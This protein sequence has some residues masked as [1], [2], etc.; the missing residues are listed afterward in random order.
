MEH[1]SYNDTNTEENSRKSPAAKIIIA[2]AIVIFLICVGVMIPFIM[3][4]NLIGD[5]IKKDTTQYNV[6]ITAVITENRVRE[7]DGVNSADTKTGKVYTPVYEYE[8]RG[9]TYSVAGSV[10]SADKK[11]DVG[12]KVNVLISD[13][14]PGRMYDPE[15]NPTKVI[16]DFGHKV[17]GTLILVLVIPLILLAA[18][19]A[20]V[21][22]IIVRASKKKGT[23]KTDEAN[24]YDG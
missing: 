15:Y 14:N 11:Y 23:A 22:I 7:S 9:K 6:P 5:A 18:V 19:T 12:Q 13:V 2:A 24:N 10:A 8:Y 17:S 20:A 3:A 21:I 4:K 16:D 1:N